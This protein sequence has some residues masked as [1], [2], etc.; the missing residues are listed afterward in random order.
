MSATS[1]LIAI[2]VRMLSER[3]RYRWS[4]ASRAVAA[5]GGGYVAASLF[6]L[7]VP[8]LLAQFGVNQAQALLAATT[9]SFLLYGAIIMAVFHARSATRAWAW[10]VGSALP[11]GIV[12]L[13]L[14]PG[15]RI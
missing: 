1:F 11:L 12:I 6:N 14:L 2:H 13:L 7:A 8:L 5:V 15:A 9:A 4:V 3:A 10:L